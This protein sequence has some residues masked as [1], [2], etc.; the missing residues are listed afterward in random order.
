M[1][2]LGDNPNA[3]DIAEIRD[4]P[5]LDIGQDGFLWTAF[6]TGAAGN[7]GI[8]NAGFI[9]IADLHRAIGTD[10]Y[11]ATA[12]ITLFAVYPRTHLFLLII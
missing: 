1:A 7:T 2:L 3:V 5:F 9:I 12:A 11:T 10:F 8:E 6:Y 4:S